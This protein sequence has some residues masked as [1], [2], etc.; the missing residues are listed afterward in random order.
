M[1]RWQEMALT[2]EDI[3]ALL[4]L[5]DEDPQLLEELRRRI[6]P[7]HFVF[8]VRLPTEWMAQVDRRLANLERD[9]VRLKGISKEIAFRQKASSYLGALLKGGR[10]ASELVNEILDKAEASGLVTPQEADYVRTA[11]LLWVGAVRRGM[12]A[13]EQIIVVIEISW[14]VDEQAVERAIKKA[15]IL[16]RAGAWAVPFVSG[17]EWVSQELKQKALQQFVFCSEDGKVEPDRSDYTTIERFLE[18]WKP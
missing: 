9:V 14:V 15:Q 4:H 16:R 5:L 6:L 11:D 2:R 17:E 18:V 12:F 10:E 13:N 7:D 8:E 1:R 3:Y